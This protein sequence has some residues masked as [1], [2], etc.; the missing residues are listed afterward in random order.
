VF[1]YC[2]GGSRSFKGK[3]LGKSWYSIFLSTRGGK[4]GEF[5]YNIFITI[6]GGKLGFYMQPGGISQS[7]FKQNF[8][9]KNK[10][11]EKILISNDRPNFPATNPSTAIPSLKN[12]SIKT[13]LN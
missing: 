7:K 4:L 2:H 6:R 3:K 1:V 11:T 13:T 10:K 5:W 12:Q 9:A 8:P